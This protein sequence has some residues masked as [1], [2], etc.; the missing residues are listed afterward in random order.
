MDGNKERYLAMKGNDK[1]EKKCESCEFLKER[2]ENNSTK[3]TI[4]HCPFFPS[5]ERETTEKCQKIGYDKM[6]TAA[7][8]ISCEHNEIVTKFLNS[9]DAMNCFAVEGTNSTMGMVRIESNIS[10]FLEFQLK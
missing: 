9:E 4:D 3:Y 1:F 7:M 10:N 6:L 8:R 2:M 5:M